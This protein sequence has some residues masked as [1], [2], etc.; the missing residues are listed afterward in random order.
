VVRISRD[1]FLVE[2]T[3]STRLHRLEDGYVLVRPWRGARHLVAAL[4][5]G[6]L[7][8]LA[9]RTLVW[10]HPMLLPKDPPAILV[11]AGGI[12]VLY[13]VLVGL[14][15]QT[16]I[17]VTSGSTRIWRG[18]LPTLGGRLRMLPPLH[19]VRLT[20]T[21]GSG[22]RGAAI[23]MWMVEGSIG[24]HWIVIDLS[25]TRRRAEAMTRL[26]RRALAGA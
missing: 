19:D 14:V 6:G 1:D 22:G 7:I 26:L 13:Y 9:L 23:M 18:P 12:I 4:A 15:N 11:L 16:R 10:H 2:S 17:R 21:K 8:G 5:A 20:Q 3:G 24:G 25:W